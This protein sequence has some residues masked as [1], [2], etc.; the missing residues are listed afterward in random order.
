RDVGALLR[1]DRPDLACGLCC[2][3]Y[4][5]LTTLEGGAE[6]EAIVLRG[7]DS[8]GSSLRWSFNDM[9]ADSFVWRGEIS[10]DGGKSWRLE[11]DHHMRRRS[12]SYLSDTSFEL[13]RWR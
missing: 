6:G 3:E 11:E 1:R 13:A 4:G 5:L 9:G 10:R 8:D 2:P 12:G 7:T